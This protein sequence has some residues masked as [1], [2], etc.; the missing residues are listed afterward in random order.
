MKINILTLA[1]G[2]AMIVAAFTATA[3]MGYK[4]S[5]S[6]MNTLIC[7]NGQPCHNT[8]VVCNNGQSCTTSESNST[9][10]NQGITHLEDSGP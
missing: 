8:T 3:A 2:I 6:T 5:K 1:I 4:Q 7:T 9:A 10:S